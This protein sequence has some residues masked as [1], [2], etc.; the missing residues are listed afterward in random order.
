MQPQYDR[1]SS[2][3]L[4][5]ASS[6]P[7]RRAQLERQFRV[8]IV[9]ISPDI[10]ESA[11]T[12]ESAS[13]TAIRLSEEKAEAVAEKVNRNSVIIA[14]DQTAEFDGSL[15]RKP[16]SRKATQE[17]LRNFSNKS[18]TFYSGVCL[19]HLSKGIKMSKITATEVRF[20]SLT[21]SQIE[22]YIDLDQPFDCVGAFK[23][24]SSGI[25]LFDFIKSTDPS[26]LTGLPLIA[27]NEMLLDIGIDILEMSQKKNTTP[28][29]SPQNETN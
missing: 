23:N 11:L 14:G 3:Q 12:G 6:S 20:R 16:G 27:L 1:S 5:L 22:G 4:V 29:I 15:L 18:L 17:Q 28:N 7:Y 13:Q 24:E 9:S 8:P 10:N 21:Q 2:A 25:L 19:M 26:A